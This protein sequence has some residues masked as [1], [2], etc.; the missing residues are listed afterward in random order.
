MSKAKDLMNTFAVD[1]AS[2]KG[3]DKAAGIMKKALENSQEA[4]KCLAEVKKLRIDYLK[5]GGKVLDKEDNHIEPPESIQKLEQE[6]F[7]SL[8]QGM[9]IADDLMQALKK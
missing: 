2:R 6:L 4:E 8:K 3:W 1:E 9:G 5:E 7:D